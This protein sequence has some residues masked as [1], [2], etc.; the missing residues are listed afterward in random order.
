MQVAVKLGIVTLDEFIYFHGILG[1]LRYENIR[2]LIFGCSSLLFI[3]EVS[4]FPNFFV[5]AFRCL[6]YKCEHIN[7]EFIGFSI[8]TGLN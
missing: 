6:F 5:F 1:V 4:L 7:F 8:R 2:G 3:F